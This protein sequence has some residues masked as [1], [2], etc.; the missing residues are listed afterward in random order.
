MFSSRSLDPGVAMILVAIGCVGLLV[1]WVPELRWFLALALGCGSILAAV[2][3]VLHSR[4]R[5]SHLPPPAENL[6]PVQ[7]NFAKV[8]VDGGIAGLL[9]VVGSVGVL[10]IGLETVRWF[11]AA[12]LAC[13]ILLAVFI[14][15][16][17]REHPGRKDPESTLKPR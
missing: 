5:Q 14:A 9:V 17:R 1:V 4:Q 8:P 11:F 7:I 16:W 3:F 15:G 6:E 2:M 12:T 10:M 13:G